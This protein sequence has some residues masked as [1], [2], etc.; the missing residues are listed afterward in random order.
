MT[1]TTTED[2]M[3]QTTDSEV[4]AA[5]ADRCE[6]RQCR[7][8]VSADG[9][10]LDSRGRVWQRPRWTTAATCAGCGD[11]FWHHRPPAAGRTR[12]DGCAAAVRE[13]T[14]ESERRLVAAGASGPA[15]DL[16]VADDDE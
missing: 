8:T 3:N 1:T 16:A 10:L 12:C 15:A 13:R 14:M 7:H 6:C 5:T 9:T 2:T 4:A 11:R